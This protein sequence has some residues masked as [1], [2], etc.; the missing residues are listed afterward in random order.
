MKALALVLALCAPLARADAG[1][2]AYPTGAALDL[3][4]TERGLARGGVEGHPLL[5]NRA[6]RFALKGAETGVFV[7]LDSRIKRRKWI[8]RG[9]WVAGHL[10]VFA[11]NERR[12]R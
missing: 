10:A 9:A 6:A 3:W 4:S 5:R 7:F 12:A 11:I 1:L 2:L 8:L